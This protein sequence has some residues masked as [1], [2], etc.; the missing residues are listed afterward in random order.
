[1]LTGNNYS[2]VDWTA[3]GTPADV[4]RRVTGGTG[5]GGNGRGICLAAHPKNPNVLLPGMLKI[6]VGTCVIVYGTGGSDPRQHTTD[7]G[8]KVLVMN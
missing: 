1:M 8:F 5:P 3:Y 6:W 4:P 2:W 7:S